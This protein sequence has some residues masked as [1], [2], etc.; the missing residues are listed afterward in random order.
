MFVTLL[1][2]SKGHQERG[3]KKK[4]KEKSK[5][6]SEQALLNPAERLYFLIET[7]WRG[8]VLPFQ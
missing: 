1:M 4:R 3:E 8:D 5:N 6:G 2:T 7:G